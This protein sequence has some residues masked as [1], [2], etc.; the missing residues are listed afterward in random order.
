MSEI[1]VRNLN[2]QTHDLGSLYKNFCPVVWQVCTFGKEG[3]YSMRATYTSQLA[4]LKAQVDEG[5]IT[6]AATSVN[7]NVPVAGEEGS[8]QAKN[9]TGFVQNIALGL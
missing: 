8:M 4:F 3:S 9:E 2:Y 6:D 7:I 5:I 1:F